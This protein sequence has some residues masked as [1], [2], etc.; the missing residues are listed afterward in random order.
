VSAVPVRRVAQ[1]YV[2]YDGNGCK[3]LVK[4]SL[5]TVLPARRRQGAPTATSKHGRKEKSGRK[6]TPIVIPSTV[7]AMP[8]SSDEDG[9]T[10]LDTAGGTTPP[11][12]DGSMAFAGQPPLITSREGLIQV[13]L[14]RMNAGR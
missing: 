11:G 8:G 3:V 10:G 5:P 13:V 9:S 1:K 7:E 2:T 14:E 4:P 6:G 12:F